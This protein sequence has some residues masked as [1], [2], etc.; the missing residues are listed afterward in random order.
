MSGWAWNGLVQTRT[1]GNQPRK[2]VLMF[3]ADVANERGESYYGID[4]IVATLE[5]SDKTVRRALEQLSADGLLLRERDRRTD[6]TLGK[7]RYRLLWDPISQLPWNGRGGK[8]DPFGPAGTVTGSGTDHRSEEPPPAVTVT[9]TTGQG[10][11]AVT[12]TDNPTSEPHPA[13]AAPPPAGGVLF[14]IPT[15]VEALCTELADAIARY[16][17]TDGARPT[18][19]A[20][21]RRDMRLLLAHGPLGTAKS[22]VEPSNVRGCLAVVFTELADP[23]ASG[24][25]W[26][27][28]VD[29]PLALRR[30]WWKIRDKARAQRLQATGGK[31][32]AVARQVAGGEPVEDLAVTLAR[33]REQRTAALAVY[34]GAQVALG[35]GA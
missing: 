33:H 16:R 26:A 15:E 1:V 14:D 29:S 17:G 28:V 8:I 11:R 32:A 23:D 22:S 30:H 34:G 24:F 31:M 13:T 12:P 20:N 9:T 19:T 21:W 3:L 5:L 10:D 25:C 35:S 7:Y 27:N 18:V 6:G 2:A 4:T